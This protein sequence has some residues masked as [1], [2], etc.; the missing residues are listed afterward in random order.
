MHLLP[1]AEILLEL[2]YTHEQLSHPS[3]T[4]ISHACKIQ[5]TL[6]L[7]AEIVLIFNKC[8]YITSDFLQPECKH[9]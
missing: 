3:T 6:K 9:R 5:L 2:I 1:I 4:K 7:S 8:L